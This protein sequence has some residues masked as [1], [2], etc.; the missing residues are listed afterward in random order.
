[1]RSADLFHPYS[2]L[3]VHLI[4]CLLQSVDHFRLLLLTGSNQSSLEAPHQSV[5]ELADDKRAS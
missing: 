2:L 3:F 5:N 1:M 4:L